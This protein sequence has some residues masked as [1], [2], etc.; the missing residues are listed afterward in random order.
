MGRKHFM[1]PTNEGTPV[2]N[3][4]ITLKKEHRRGLLEIE[5]LRGDSLF[6]KKNIFFRFFKV[7]IYYFHS[8]FSQGHQ[9]SFYTDC[10]DVN[11]RQVTFS[12]DQVIQ[13]YIIS[14]CHPT[15]VDLKD[16][17]HSLFIG[18][19][20]LDLSV[21]AAWC[22]KCWIQ[23]SIWFVAMITFMSPL[24]SHPYNWFNSSNT[25]SWIP[26]S[27][28]EFESYLFFQ[29]HLLSSINMMDGACSSA[30]GNNSRMGT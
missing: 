15:C 25:V 24:E 21:N 18:Q 14:R 8:M 27:S 30:T 17:L 10:L 3:L 29:W 1:W 20:E 5:P 7:F 2:G 13:G 23:I 6:F 4:H 9:T 19:E 26:L 12:H 28:L 22:D 11:T 16:T